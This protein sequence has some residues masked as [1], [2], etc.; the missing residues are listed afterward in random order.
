MRIGYLQKRGRFLESPIRR[1]APRGGLKALRE[2]SLISSSA[3]NSVVQAPYQASLN[4]E[5]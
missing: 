4:T 1:R 3:I 2:V 5:A